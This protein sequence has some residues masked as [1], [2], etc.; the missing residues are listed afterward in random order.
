M[1]HGGPFAFGLPKITASQVERGPLGSGMQQ[2]RYTYEEFFTAI[3]KP[4]PSDH[5]GMPN[6]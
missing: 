1:P 2:A 5:L 4:K 6:E 3:A